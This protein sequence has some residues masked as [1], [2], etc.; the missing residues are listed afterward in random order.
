M[1]DPVLFE[2]G[3]VR[4]GEPFKGLLGPFHTQRLDRAWL[5]TD[6]ESSSV[7]VV[8]PE[9]AAKRVHLDLSYPTSAIDHDGS[10]YVADRYNSRVVIA[11]A[12][13]SES[14]T[15]ATHGTQ[16]HPT[17]ALP[18]RQGLYLSFSAGVVV[19][20]PLPYE[21][22]AARPVAEKGD[23]T[24]LISPRGLSLTKAG[25]LLCAD[26]EAHLVMEITPDGRL[27]WQY[28]KLGDPGPGP[29][30]LSSPKY[31]AETAEGTIL[32]CDAMNRRVTE[33]SRQGEVVSELAMT[34]QSI[35][36]RPCHVLQHAAALVVSDY[37]GRYVA[38]VGPD[39]RPRYIA[40]RPRYSTSLFWN[41]RSVS[42]C[43][44]NLLVSDTYADRIL[45]TDLNGR[46][47]KAWLGPNKGPRF[48]WPRA[49]AAAPDGRLAV[50]DGRNS[51]F[52]WMDASGNL[53]A[54]MTRLPDGTPFS[55]PHEI[56]LIG[57]DT[58]LLVDSAADLVAVITGKGDLIWR[59]TGRHGLKDP[60]GA[61]LVGDV[62]VIC[63]TGNDRL[64]AIDKGG[65]VVTTLSTI[66]FDEPLPVGQPR[67]LTG[68]GDRFYV[69]QGSPPAVYLTDLAGRGYWSLDLP[70]EYGHLCAPRGLCLTNHRNRS[71]LIVS[72][73][74]NCRLLGVDVDTH[75]PSH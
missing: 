58:W 10:L 54:E 52:V 62:F 27:V 5:V 23:K 40:G 69:A 18:T 32:I 41:Q 67:V 17:F 66:G 38:L 64:V 16:H 44:R 43:G 51:R 68:L 13:Q 56:S 45:L 74:E 47:L 25:N 48:H 71:V 9:E 46:L 65:S 31:A 37:I 15:V 59:T 60:H 29:G 50:A 22:A 7:L 33:V 3:P 21:A 63:D 14:P 11:D 72:D 4:T 26:D 70:P 2:I 35:L 12:Y 1:G 57:R 73:T 20:A 53:L 30:Q 39:A 6:E 8:S 61:R 28:G 75:D 55:D 34:A 24:P 19:R 36:W 49:C 42:R